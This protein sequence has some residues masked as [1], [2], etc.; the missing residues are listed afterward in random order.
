M[1]FD[2]LGVDIRYQYTITKEK[3]QRIDMNRDSTGTNI[4][5]LLEYNPSQ[6]MVSI[7]INILNLSNIKSKK[8]LRSG[9][10]NHKYL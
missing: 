1:E 8:G 5:D 7:H 2:I 10:R 6:I 4:A 9:W 3:A